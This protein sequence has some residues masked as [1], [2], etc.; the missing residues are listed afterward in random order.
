M[1]SNVGL[2]ARFTKGEEVKELRDQDYPFELGDTQDD[3]SSW[4]IGN[5]AE[6]YKSLQRMW[7]HDQEIDRRI[8]I[9]DRG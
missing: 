2:E 6:K 3:T 5:D 7:K 1:D 8:A 9:R 4:H